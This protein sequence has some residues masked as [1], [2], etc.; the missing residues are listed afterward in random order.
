VPLYVRAASKIVSACGKY[1]SRTFLLHFE[2][3]A[4]HYIPDLTGDAWLWRW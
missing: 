2:T 4:L 3:Y 1:L